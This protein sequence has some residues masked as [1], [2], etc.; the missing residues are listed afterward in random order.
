MERSDS[1]L[2][3]RGEQR[4]PQLGRPVYT[5]WDMAKGRAAKRARKKSRRN[6]VRAAAWSAFHRRRRQRR[7]AIALTSIILIGV[8]AG[9]A[10]AAFRKPTS[11]KPAATPEAPGVVAPRLQP[12]A[13]GAKI[14]S[15]AGSRKMAYGSAPDQRLDPKKRTVVH[16]QTSCGAFDVALDVA[17]SPKT[18]NS[19]AFLV[20]SHFYDGLVF[21]RI[22]PDFV[23]QGGD[24][25]GDGSGG[26]GYQVVE[27]PPAG[28]KY[29]KGTVAMA[30][31]S[32]DPPGASSS[33]F[34]VVATDR[35][36]SVLTPEYAVLGTVTKGMDVVAK[37]MALATGDM[38]PPKAYAYIESATLSVG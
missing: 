37:I 18:S 11:D 25:K 14:P 15:T 3:V 26:S 1:Y 33:Q 9:L 30:K 16:M 36:Q 32:S 21:H 34:F 35:G 13:C 22:S 2:I 8:G 4:S 6:E 28:F 19:F 7:I 31:G 17:H 5:H 24:P 23:I 10:F 20:R 12:V 29:K 38:S 27:P